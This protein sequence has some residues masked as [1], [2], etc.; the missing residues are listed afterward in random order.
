LASEARVVSLV[1]KVEMVSWRDA[2]ASILKGQYVAKT[3]YFCVYQLDKILEN[4]LL[5]ILKIL[6]ENRHQARQYQ[7]NTP[8]MYCQ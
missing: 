6:S 2:M 5:N 3:I 7:P 4:S 8:I 1:L